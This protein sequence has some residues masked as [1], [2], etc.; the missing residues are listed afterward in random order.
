[1]SAPVKPSEFRALISDTSA[2]MCD[3]FVKTLLRLPILIYRFFNWLLDSDGN[4]TAAAKTEISKFSCPTGSVLMNASST[5][6]DGFLLCNGAAVSRTTYA[7]LFAAIGTTFGDGDTTT[8]F[9][10]PDM[11][12]KF[13]IGAGTLAVAATGGAAQVSLTASHIPAH[14]H[15]VPGVDPP[16]GGGSGTF[17]VQTEQDNAGVAD[18]DITTT[19]FGGSP[20]TPVDILPPY[21]ALN[22]VIKT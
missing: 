9:N 11:R 4:F 14:T 2:T 7:A 22:F 17:Y 19:S 6:P 3:N 1:M 15:G 21:V 16:G 10:V 12:S 8:T 5:V 13:A 18:R 20:V